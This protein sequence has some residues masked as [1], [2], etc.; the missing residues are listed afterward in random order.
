MK[1]FRYFWLLPGFMLMCLSTSSHAQY[2][3]GVRGGVNFAKFGPANV[4]PYNPNVRPNTA[5]VF[6]KSLSDALSIQLEAGFSGRGTK[7]DE[8]TEGVYKG[9]MFRYESSGSLDINYIEMP[10]LLQY[11]CGVGPF[12]LILSAG[13][14]VKLLVGKTR[15][16]N[17]SRIF[18]EGVLTSE[19]SDDSKS[20]K[21]DDF[22]GFDYGLTGGAGLAYPMRNLKLF[23]EARYH[24]GLRKIM[25]N[26]FHS[27]NRGLS[28]H[29]G[30][31]FPIKL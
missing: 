2:H 25:P 8:T 28:A 26:G 22:R 23:A 5:I 20:R 1:N 17:N 7:Y 16:K 9:A 31:L 3:I 27:N 13:P 14:D 11:R 19:V 15:A 10:V 12:D 24:L 21:G 6:N 4:I 29:A 18:R 30:V